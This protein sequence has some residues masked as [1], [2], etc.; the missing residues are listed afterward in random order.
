MIIISQL[1]RAYDAV[2]SHFDK[3]AAARDLRAMSDYQLRDMG[4]ARDQI[5]DLVYGA[6]E[7]KTSA[8]PAFKRPAFGIAQLS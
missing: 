4:I 3:A 5:D 1:A 7:A 2:R 8:D 6:R